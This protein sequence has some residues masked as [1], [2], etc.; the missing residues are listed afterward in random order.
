MALVLTH[1]H[2]D[3]VTKLPASIAAMVQRDDPITTG[4]SV[5]SVF[6]QQF[7]RCEQFLINF[8]GDDAIR[9]YVAVCES[10]RNDA[11]RMFDAIEAA[12]MGYG[13][14]FLF[15]HFLT[16]FADRAFLPPDMGAEDV[17]PLASG[18]LSELGFDK[19]IFEVVTFVVQFASV[20]DRATFENSITAE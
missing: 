1:S 5:A 11:Q 14:K 20:E 16:D 7:V 13:E 17:L 2:T 3:M 19:I 9:L 4:T 18:Y 8:A 6:V 10:P 15:C 12:G